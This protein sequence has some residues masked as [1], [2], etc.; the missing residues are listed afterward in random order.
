MKDIILRYG[1]EEIDSNLYTKGEWILV[2][3]NDEFEVFGDPEINNRYFHGKIDQL[4]DVLND[5]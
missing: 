3:Y 4:E 2:I 5:L 1:F